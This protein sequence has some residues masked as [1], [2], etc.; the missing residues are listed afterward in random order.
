[1][2]GCSCRGTA[3]FAHLSCLAE[4]AKILVEDAE[5]RNLDDG[6]FE[7]W[8]ACSL[9]EQKYHGVVKCA[10]GWACWKAYLGRPEA[11]WARGS[12][13]TA[14]GTGLAAAARHE[15][16]LSVQE[17]ALSMRR[18]HGAPEESMLS[19]QNNLAISYDALGRFERALQMKREVYSGRLKLNG[20]EHEMTLRAANNYT[21]TLL[22]LR[23]FEEAKSVLRK[24]APVAR[25]IVGEEHLLTLKM[26]KNYARALCLNA[27]ATLDDLRE[28]VTTLEDVERVARR[29]LGGTHP[30]AMN[31]EASLRAARAA[32]RARETPST[33]NNA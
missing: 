6:K 28:A 30:L 19:A 15:D 20:E 3:G 33:S 11:D 5:E 17:A 4:Q 31:I 21:D 25:R 1:M 32:L 9:C 22:R 10:L 2:R 12:A 18:R 13:M 7:R 23:R 14:L 24:A 27:G 26:R 8:Y 16:A 29:V